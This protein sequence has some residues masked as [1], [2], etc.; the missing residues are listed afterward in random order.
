MVEFAKGTG[1]TFINYVDS[2]LNKITNN[3]HQKYLDGKSNSSSGSSSKVDVETAGKM[4]NNS[5]IM[6]NIEKA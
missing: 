3:E 4:Q 6:L 1:P 2:V 5:G